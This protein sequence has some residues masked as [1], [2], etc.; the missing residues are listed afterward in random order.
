MVLIYFLNCFELTNGQTN[1]INNNNKYKKKKKS[2]LFPLFPHSPENKCPFQLR[3]I[4]KWS[5]DKTKFPILAATNG[6]KV[7]S[8]QEPE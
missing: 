7:K 5:D 3:E 4:T 1:N 6:E 8:K 2:L